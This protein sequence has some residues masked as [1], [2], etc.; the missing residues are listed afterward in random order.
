MTFSR[1]S[2][3]PT[4]CHGKPCIKGHRVM[5]HQILDYIADGAS[6]E[7]TLSEFPGITKADIVACLEYASS[8]IKNEEVHIVR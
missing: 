2:S 8:I 6:F 1:I 4:I 3:K 5:V 7:E